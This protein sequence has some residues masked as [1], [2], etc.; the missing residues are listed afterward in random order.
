ML[1]PYL[2][3]PPRSTVDAQVAWRPLREDLQLETQEVSF[4]RVGG[5]LRPSGALLKI[6]HCGVY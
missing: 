6:V 1:R 3:L 5:W 4:F 2:S